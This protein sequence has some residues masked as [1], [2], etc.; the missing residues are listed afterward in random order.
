MNPNKDY[1]LYRLSTSLCVCTVVMALST[2]ITRQATQVITKK[3]H[4]LNASIINKK[5]TLNMLSSEWCHLNSPNHL[6]NINKKKVKLK[7]V[8]PTQTSSL[9]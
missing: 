4:S 9:A 8:H 6:Q 2:Y 3:I 1:F 7:S 5:R